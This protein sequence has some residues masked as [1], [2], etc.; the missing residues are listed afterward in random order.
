MK[1]TKKYINQVERDH[2]MAPRPFNPDAR[3]GLHDA[4]SKEYTRFCEE[5]PN[6]TQSE[7]KI[8]YA[9]IFDELEP[10]YPSY[11]EM[12]SDYFSTNGGWVKTNVTCRTIGY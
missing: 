11:G 2:S 12:K 6:V 7:R 8:A 3:P 1:K 10:K 9:R 5:N 4:V